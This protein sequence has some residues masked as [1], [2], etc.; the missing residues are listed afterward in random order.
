MANESKDASRT[1][2]SIGVKSTTIHDVTAGIDFTELMPRRV[3]VRGLGAVGALFV[4]P[5]CSSESND[6]PAAD[7][8]TPNSTWEAEA[9][10]FEAQGMG[11]YSAAA[12]KD[13]A[14]KEG[15]HVPKVELA[16]KTAKISTTH[17]TEAVS[18]EKPTGHF[19]SHHYLREGTHGTIFAWKKY[20]LKPGET[21]SGEFTIPDGVKSFTAYQV[22]N[23]HWTWTTTGQ[24][25]G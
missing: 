4:V 7:A 24:D 25:V 12:T 5:G 13:Q 8:L 18:T 10:T 11:L 6:D 1:P 2:T 14:G 3:F 16:G 19:I 9:A 21:A 17:A 20:D 22:C 23:L 15:S